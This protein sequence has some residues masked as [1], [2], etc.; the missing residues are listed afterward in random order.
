MIKNDFVS[1]IITT[2]NRKE[3]LKNAINSVLNQTYKNFELIIIDDCSTE[4]IEQF[5]KN[6]FKSIK[7]Y[8]NSTNLGVS[9]SRNKGIELASFETIAFLDDDD[10]W[11]PN[12]LQICMNEM[13]SGNYDFVFTQFFKNSK[14]Y[15]D[16]TFVD[17]NFIFHSI[18]KNPIL[19]PSTFVCKKNILQ[20]VGLFDQKIKCFE[21]YELSL[22]IAKNYNGK[23]IPLALTTVNFTE[24]SLS[25]NNNAIEGL[26]TRIEL[27][28]K[29]NNFLKKYHLEKEWL[30]GITNFQYF[31]EYNIYK[32]LIHPVEMIMGFNFDIE[33]TCIKE[34]CLNRIVPFK[35]FDSFDKPFWS[36]TVKININKL[37]MF[38]KK[39]KYSFYGS[40]SYI[41]L[42]ACNNV[43]N[44]RLRKEGK[45]IF[46]YANLQAQ[47]TALT[48]S[49]NAD[50]TRRIK[51]NNF[52]TFIKNF[53][54]LKQ[55]TFNESIPPHHLEIYDDV[56]F[57]SCLPWF[58]IKHLEPVM[59][60]SWK[61]YIPRITWGKYF[62][63][64]QQYFINISL[65][66]HHA[67]VDGFH[68]QQLL[69]EIEKQI[70]ILVDKK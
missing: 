49:G 18:L 54:E 26:K 28:I 33:R 24:N 27:F 29:Y 68:V 39:N 14:V 3:K 64:N 59:N 20:N 44:F 25:S 51:N 60:Y 16:S 45:Y 43:R 37:V 17:N 65:T 12:K 31:M 1:V 22:R 36:V 56:I 6:N 46:D 23:F 67:F 10:E 30:K 41:L 7:Y 11:L 34:E 58:D 52:I 50:I 15:P 32:K 13:R 66:V 4:E 62:I 8:K 42:N 9:A 48:K 47:F 2:Y 55:E 38:C 19:S 57:L 63:E 5:I 70:D 21:D 40:M 53:N 35:F 61:D 69:C